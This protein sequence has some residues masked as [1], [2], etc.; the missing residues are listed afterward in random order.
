MIQMLKRAIARLLTR[1]TQPSV[2]PVEQTQTAGRA[3]P[4]PTRQAGNK[5]SAATTKPQPQ[6]VRKSRTPKSSVA[7]PTTQAPSRKQGS[8]PVQTTSGKRG[9]PRKT[10]V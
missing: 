9:R 5:L 4:E 2:A 8:K 1:Q 6:A 10:A 3:H 7:Q